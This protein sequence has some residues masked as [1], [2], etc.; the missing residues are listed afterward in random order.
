MNGPSFRTSL[1]NFWRSDMPFA[2]RCRVAIRN[3][4]IKARTRQ[5]C[6]GN[7]GEPGC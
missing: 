2:Q 6:C 5:D 1:K 7:H 4:L 3:N